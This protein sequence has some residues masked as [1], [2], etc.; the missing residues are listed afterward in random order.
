MVMRV[1][2]IGF[3]RE[4]ICRK[5][6][7]PVVMVSLGLAGCASGP[8]IQLPVTAV[9]DQPGVRIVD[10]TRS[11]A[12]ES[13]NLAFGYANVMSCRYGIMKIDGDKIAPTPVDY[14]RSYLSSKV[15]S[16]TTIEV[17][18]FDI[19]TNSSAG[20]HK[21]LAGTAIH[22]TVGAT[23]MFGAYKPPKDGTLIGCSEAEA[24][25]YTSGEVKASAVPILI[26][27]IG[28]YDGKP[29]R[30]RTIS[31]LNAVGVYPS[32]TDLKIAMDT[33]LAALV[34]RFAVDR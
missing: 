6:L 24:G 15:P 5:K 2:R 20:F 8:T 11:R 31:D 13:S 29:F 9:P 32:P 23:V 18:R 4:M 7:L 16:T 10:K 19:Y 28:T 3:A 26:Y 25:E 27:L 17:D 1:M 34:K 21:A 22:T 30:L 12:P 14:M 33:T